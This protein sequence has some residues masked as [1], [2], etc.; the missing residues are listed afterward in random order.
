MTLKMLILNEL[1]KGCQ[2]EKVNAHTLGKTI[3]T[4]QL[5]EV[6]KKI[7][8]NKSLGM[9]GITCEFLKV[10]WGKL[11]FFYYQGIKHMF[12]KR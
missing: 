11:K 5:S 8:H 12:S 4:L 9:D 10:F 6:L 3:S 1:L 2:V 7:K